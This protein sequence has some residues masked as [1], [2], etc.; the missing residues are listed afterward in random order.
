LARQIAQAVF[1]DKVPALFEIFHSR[2]NRHLEEGSYQHRPCLESYANIH[3]LHALADATN[4][5]VDRVAACLIVGDVWHAMHKIETP[6]PIWQLMVA[7]SYIFPNTAHDELAYLK[8][9]NLKAIAL[10]QYSY[11]FDEDALIRGIKLL[12]D[13]KSLKD[14]VSEIVFQLVYIFNLRCNQG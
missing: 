4:I 5:P 10:V 3:G 1:R 14:K 11:L 9:Q 8:A 12:K 6:D 2:E 7:N 13:F